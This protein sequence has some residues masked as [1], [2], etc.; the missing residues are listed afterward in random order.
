MNWTSLTFQLVY[1]GHKSLSFGDG[2]KSLQFESFDDLL[3]GMY[4]DVANELVD[5]KCK[6]LFN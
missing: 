5:S 1:L 2:Y 4:S 6:N 3:K